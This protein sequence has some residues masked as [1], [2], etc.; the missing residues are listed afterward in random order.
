MS[1]R[2]NPNDDRPLR[3]TRGR[4]RKHRVIYVAVEG[5]ITEVHYFDYVAELI[6]DRQVTLHVLHEKNGLKPQDT[7][8][9]ILDDVDDDAERWVMF[10]RDQHNKIPEA[11]ARAKRN[12]VNVVFSHPSF[13]LWLLLHFT[14]FSG[15]QDGSSGV[16]HLKLRQQA[17]FEKFGSDDKSLKGD[18]V[19]AI[20]G[21]ELTATRNARK[22]T[23]DCTTAECSEADGHADHCQPLGRDPSTDV[24]QLLASLK[25]IDA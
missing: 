10:D 5:E 24:W 11:F 7:V 3:K 6:A 19:K 14:P 8:D 9:K 22:L 15:A 13:D 23:N 25:I 16:V 2:S 20:R 21:K 1:R 4:S 12:N 18:R 17:S